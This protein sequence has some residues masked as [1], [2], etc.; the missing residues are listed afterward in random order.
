MLVMSDILSSSN[1]QLSDSIFIILDIGTDFES[2]AINETS[3]W[4]FLCFRV[5]GH[6]PSTGILE[7]YMWITLCLLDRGWVQDQIFSKLSK[8]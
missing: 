2:T 7:F 3:K 1:N 8:E 5:S 6:F 4:S